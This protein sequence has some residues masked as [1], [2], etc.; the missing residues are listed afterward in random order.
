MEVKVREDMS[1]SRCGMA[2]HN[3]RNMA[4]PLRAYTGEPSKH[5]ISSGAGAWQPCSAATEQ[6]HSV[7]ANCVRRLVVH[8]GTAAR[9]HARQ[10]VH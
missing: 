8:A 9:V 4:C 10:E 7:G 6:Q 2:G 1:C 3:A 5:P